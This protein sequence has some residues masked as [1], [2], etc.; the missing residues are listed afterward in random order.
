MILLQDAVWGAGYEGVVMC[1]L[2]RLLSCL[3][4]VESMGTF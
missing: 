4:A 2:G 3:V 1:L